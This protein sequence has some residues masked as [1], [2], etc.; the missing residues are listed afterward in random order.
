MHTMGNILS[1][2]CARGHVCAV[3]CYYTIRKFPQPHGT[4]RGRDV[5]PATKNTNHQRNQTTNGVDASDSNENPTPRA[6]SGKSFR[7]QRTPHNNANARARV[8]LRIIGKCDF[9]C[10]RLSLSLS[11]LG[12][13]RGMMLKTHSHVFAFRFFGAVRPVFAWR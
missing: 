5:T 9:L 2:T 10:V 6:K 7:S 11:S 3:W 4:P 13:L 12:A 8:S 1:S